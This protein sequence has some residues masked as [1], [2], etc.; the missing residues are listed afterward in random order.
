ME[1]HH[2]TH[3]MV[4]ILVISSRE[5]ADL[6]CDADQITLQCDFSGDYTYK[7]KT[8]VLLPWTGCRTS[9]RE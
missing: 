4:D 1:S 2:V 8:V 7:M 3:V 9:R 5:H 6:V